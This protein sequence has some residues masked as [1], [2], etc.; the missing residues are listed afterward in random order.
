MSIRFPFVRKDRLDVPSEKDLTPLVLI[1]P[2]P[3]PSLVILY[4]AAF[5]LAFAKPIIDSSASLPLPTP[6]DSDTIDQLNLNPTSQYSPLSGGSSATVASPI[7]Q[8]NPNF[9]G[10][11]DLAL[12]GQAEGEVTDQITD[13]IIQDSDFSG[14]EVPEHVVSGI[15]PS[16]SVI[17]GG[18]SANQNLP[19][20]LGSTI[21]PS[22]T[23][24][25]DSDSS[26][27]E[28]FR[29]LDLSG[30][31]VQ[32]GD[33][34]DQTLDGMR[35]SNNPS[36]AVAGGHIQSHMCS[37]NRARSVERQRKK[38]NPADI[39]PPKK[40]PATLRG[41][42]PPKPQP[43]PINSPVQVS[44]PVQAPQ[45]VPAPQPEPGDQCYIV[46]DCENIDG[47][48]MKVYCCPY[49]EEIGYDDRYV[50]TRKGCT[51]CSYTFLLF[52][53]SIWPDT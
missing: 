37:P 18:D 28:S 31:A 35:P 40:A 10:T 1:M 29:P 12:T 36:F 49:V 51:D 22:E 43:Q 14:Q 7:N 46:P 26:K 42:R 11:I 24:V 41:P 27:Q 16:K 25:Q 2:S 9:F 17:Q 19:V 52:V 33:S 44:E 3:V 5:R 30:S 20:Q 32:D 8:D 4:I 15:V 21:D 6:L 45:L 13:P 47:Q 50:S 48:P 34:S 53:S 38:R 23:I 39:D